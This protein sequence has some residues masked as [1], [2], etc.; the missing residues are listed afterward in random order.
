MDISLLQRPPGDSEGASEDRA[1]DNLPAA[2]KRRR[3]FLGGWRTVVILLGAAALAMVIW[4]LRPSSR[5]ATGGRFGQGGPMP[6][7]IAKVAKGD[8]A[9][10]LNALGTVT[11]LATVTVRPQVSGQLIKIN[12]DEGQMTSPGDVIAEIDPRPYQAQLD[13]AKGQ[14]ARDQASLEN[15]KVDLVRYKALLVKNAAA[16]QQVATQIATVHQYEGAVQSDQAEVEAAQINLDY[17]KITATVTGKVG[18]RQV[19]IGN[20]VQANNTTI[21]VQTQLQPI[22]VLFS[23]PEDS[24][25]AIVDRV[26]AGAK[27]EADAY[28]RGQVNKIA[29]GALA[30]IDNQIDPTTGQ[31]KLRA[32]FDNADEGLFPNQFVNIRLLVNTLRDQV[33][34]PGAAIE[35]G[36][37]GAY[38]FVVNDD[39]TVSMRGVTEG[40]ADG[41]TASVTTGLQVGET[42]VVDGADRLRDGARVLL[43]GQTPPPPGAS[44][45]GRGGDR[46]GGFGGRRN[47]QGGQGG[48]Q[49]QGQ[50]RQNQGEGGP[51][52]GGAAPGSSGSGAPGTSAPGSA[53]PSANGAPKAAAPNGGL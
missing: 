48:G 34:L 1:G 22:S 31:V 52:A 42:V 12:F 43:P 10:T 4:Q 8:I 36:A 3:S 20:L 11:P 5:P 26:N 25:N 21:V 39:S 50:H 16:E 9:V 44:R 27:L 24:I 45:G 28:D 40:P 30:T 6:V 7:G 38:V 35:H 13:Q 53:G 46:P 2:K 19:D 14:L 33:T 29:V 47:G 51:S 41:D 49:W 17:C 15:A 18:L 23:V 32:L 37:S